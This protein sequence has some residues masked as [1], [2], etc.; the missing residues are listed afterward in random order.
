MVLKVWFSKKAKRVVKTELDL[1]N[2]GNIDERF[3][4]NFLSRGLVRLAT[5][6]A[7]LFSNITPDSLNNKI[8]ERFR[9]PETFTQEIA[10]EDR[11]SF[12]VI[13]ASVNLMVAGIFISIATTSESFYFIRFIHF[14]SISPQQIHTSM[15][16]TYG[17]VKSRLW[18]SK[19]KSGT[20]L[21]LDFC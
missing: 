14:I 7:N 1:S 3:E 21:L 15:A 13:R 4:P 17:F 2:Q 10:K 20:R 12:D 9:V 18:K 11:P 19:S 8:E 6:S 5:N 16:W